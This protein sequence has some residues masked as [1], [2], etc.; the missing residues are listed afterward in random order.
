M[1]SEHDLDP[2][3]ESELDAELH[4]LVPMA[5]LLE[6]V[7]PYIMGEIPARSGDNP[8]S[9]AID[10]AGRLADFEIVRIIGRGGMGVVYEAI[11]K[12]LGRRV[13]LK[14]L[15]AFAAN[16]PRKVRRFQVEAQ[17][18]AGLQH[19]HIVPVHLVGAEN[20]LYYY[21][22]QYI[23]GQT[24]ADAIALMRTGE[25]ARASLPENSFSSPRTAAQLIRQAALALHFA[26]EQGTIHRD[27]KP[28][29]LLIDHGGKIWV[30]DFGLARIA[31]QA[32]LTLSGTVLGTLRYMSPEQAQGAR[33][34]IDHRTDVYSLGITL[35]ELITLRPAFAGED[36]LELLR[37]I[38]DEE[39][40]RPR[41][42]DPAIPRDL[43]TIVRKSICKRPDERY[44]TAADFADDLGRFLARQPI[45]ARPPS[46]LDRAAKWARRHRTAV[47]AAVVFTLAAVILLDSALI[48]RDAVLLHR[49]GELRA[50]LD[51]AERTESVTRH[52]LYDYQVRQAHRSLT[53]GNVEL[54][55]E[56]LNEVEATP[57]T[58][59]PR[60]FEWH[61]L[62]AASHRDVSVLSHS[63]S[64]TTASA[65]APDGQ[66]LVTGHST[67]VIVFWDLAQLR[68]RARFQAYSRPVAGLA[69]SPDGRTMGSRSVY[70]D[71]VS[72]ATLWDPATLSRLG[73]LSG[74]KGYAIDLE[75][76]ADGRQV[77]VID[78][79]LSDRHDSAGNRL[80]N[81]VRFWNLPARSKNAIPGPPSIPGC[82]MAYSRNGRWIAIS[83]ARGEVT[84]RDAAILTPIKTIPKAFGW[85]AELAASPDGD[86]IAVADGAGIS[87]WDVPTMA[88]RGTIPCSIHFPPRF[89]PDGASLA[90]LLD[91]G[92][93]ILLVTDIRSVPRR[94]PLETKFGKELRFAFSPDGKK[95]A[96][97]GIDC[98]PTLWDAVSGKPI[99]ELPAKGRRVDSLI[100]AN[101]GESLIVP[102]EGGPTHIWHVDKKVEPVVQLE[103]HKREVWG[104]AYSP[105]GDTLFS[106]SDDHTIKRWDARTGLLRSTLNGHGS[107]VTSISMRFDGKMLASAG[108]DGKVR[109]W[110]LPSG[111]PRAVL[112]GRTDRIRSVAFS[113][114]G[115]QVAS[116]AADGSIGLWD[117]PSGQP[118]S[119]HGGHGDGLHAVTFHPGGKLL[120]SAGN[121]HAIRG[122][123]LPAA[124]E[125]FALTCPGVNLAVA[126]SPDGTV[127]MSGDDR[128]N[129]TAWSSATWTRLWSSKDS[130]A[131]I[132]RLAFSPEGNT[133]AAACDDAKIRLWDP[134]TGQLLLVLDGHKARVNAAVF[135]PDG[136]TLASGSHDGAI[137]LWKGR[138]PPVLR[139]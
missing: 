120:V 64:L 3:A 128:G 81:W 67:G 6:R 108:Y 44:A 37:R 126:F 109:L 76:I 43:D 104:L 2:I 49:N 90:A 121:D 85:I 78:H 61:H 138:E 11:Q 20:G 45:R 60:G 117:V 130:E 88:M 69:F 75:F 73:N 51:R 32:D 125:V 28:S 110:D 25:A 113:P 1:G 123:E 105:H 26:H 98:P 42:L 79:D 127:L 63:E 39:P 112:S 103:G 131:P 111:H 77:V 93:S 41:V 86:S 87:I 5:E 122:I 12:S 4:S 7:R 31:G 100:F 84:L 116:G 102:S 62:R 36:R 119:V 68:E 136:K 80:D 94:V 118:K 82:K 96:G 133:L 54:A 137:M 30:S 18:A 53:S 95:L 15:P 115:R 47:A 17:A 139:Q 8:P 57:S 101:R 40:P 27:V 124:R 71:T 23:E 33:I 56:L 24:L 132:R 114:D 74:I 99:M 134:I 38:T 46:A 48:W 66:T 97:G 107:L 59:D 91:G 9:A 22:M 21:A 83:G 10:L 52:H 13:A 50:L 55:Q 72:E 58:P 16:D 135:S 65:L 129:L 14:I 34:G 106:A 29:N 35:Y 89:S 92:N 19:S 70:H